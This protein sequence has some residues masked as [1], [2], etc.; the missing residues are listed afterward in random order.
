MIELNKIYNQDCLEGMEEIEDKSIDMILCDL[1]YGSTSSPW[2]IIIPFD[3]LW[4][5][6]ERIIKDNGCIALNASQPFASQL[7][8]SNLK[9]FKYEWIWEKSH[10]TGFIHAKKRPMNYHEHIIIFYKKQPTYNPIMTIGKPN[11]GD[12]KHKK[13]D[14]NKSNSSVNGNEVNCVEAKKDGL[15]YPKSIQKFNCVNRNGILHSTQ[16]PLEMCEYLINTYTNEGELILDNCMG[17]GTTAV[18]CINL[19]RN[20]IGFDNGKDD[21]TGRYWVDVAK[22]RIEKHLTK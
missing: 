22:E 6:Y 15:K 18:A 7:I 14:K 21:K 9:L 10:P 17:S 13:G 3:K 5:Q 20:Y 19:K 16:K 12:N 4:E 2:D 8:L 11:H 1:P